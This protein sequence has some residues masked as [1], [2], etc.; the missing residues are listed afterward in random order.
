MYIY[1]KY[2]AQEMNKMFNMQITQFTDLSTETFEEY[3]NKFQKEYGQVL[4]PE[5]LQENSDFFLYHHETYGLL[6]GACLHPSPDHGFLLSHSFFHLPDGADIQYDADAFNAMCILFYK[7]LLEQV[8]QY[9]E[10]ENINDLQ[11]VGHG[12]EIDDMVCFG[13]WPLN[14]ILNIN[15]GCQVAHLIL[16]ESL[17]YAHAH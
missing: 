14:D 2:N 16:G 8:S 4:S 7:T 9:C 15:D 6:G 10:Q 17:R 1:I 5:C 3:Q 12:N 11:I 13:H